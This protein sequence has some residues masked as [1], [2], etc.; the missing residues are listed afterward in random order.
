MASVNKFIGVGNLTGDPTTRYLP[1][2]GAVTNFSIACNEQWKA[3]DGTKQEKVEYIRISTFQKLAEICGE[4]LKKG[5]LV[6]LEGRLQTRKWTDKDGV[7][8]Y[9]TEIIADKMQM[10][11]GKPDGQA[12]PRPE[13]KP[14]QSANKQSRAPAANDFED[15]ILF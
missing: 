6:Y 3:K 10:L 5:S 14:E 7:E 11:S 2:G 9:T 13:P 12:T 15:D 1:D 4:Y 8:K